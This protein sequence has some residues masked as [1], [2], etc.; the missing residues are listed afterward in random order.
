VPFRSSALTKILR[1]SF[2]GNSKTSLI[3]NVSPTLKNGKETLSALRFG[4]RAAAVRNVPVANEKRS[5]EELRRLVDAAK[6]TEAFQEDYERELG[7]VLQRL[8]SAA[9]ALYAAVPAGPRDTRIKHSLVSNF[10]VRATLVLRA[11]SQRPRLTCLARTT[12]GV[13]RCCAGVRYSETPSCRDSA[14]DIQLLR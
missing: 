10:S 11:L 1:N 8:K 7:A 5:V 6:A 12:S 9:L 3:I 14:D 2:G 13:E 4:A